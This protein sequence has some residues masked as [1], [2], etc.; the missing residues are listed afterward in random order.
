MALRTSRRRSSVATARLRPIGVIRSTLK[1]RRNAPRQGA[2]GA[3]DAWLEV[4]PW[5]ARALEGLTVGDEVFLIT[6]LHRARRDI[7]RVQGPD[8]V[9]YLQGQLSQDVEALAA[10]TSAFTL[11]LEPDGKLGF[12]L[13]ITRAADDELLL[14]VDG[15]WGEP[16][17]DR[18]E[19]FKLRVQADVEL[20]DWSCV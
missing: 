2:E 3:P 14:D 11:L 20:L 18:L 7:L 19:R 16:L 4:K 12:W 6:W 1:L 13:R 8:A 15:G 9:S 17:R 10:R 5:A